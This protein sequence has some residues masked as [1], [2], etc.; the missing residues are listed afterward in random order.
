MHRWLHTVLALLLLA[1]PFLTQVLAARGRGSLLPW[2]ITGWLLWRAG[3]DRGSVR[4]LWLGLGLALLGGSLW[5]GPQVAHWVPAVAFLLVAW[6]F[7]RT[8]V[9]PPPLI[10]RIVRLQFRDIPPRLLAYTRRLTWIWAFF[11]LITAGISTGLTM[12][13]SEHGWLW[14]HGIGAYLAMAGLLGGEYL[15]RRWRFP[16]LDR[17]PPPHETLREIVKHGKRLWEE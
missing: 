6:G 12:A 5:L 1:Y 4:W 9:H 15:Y 8:L 2:L 11:F 17:A 13:G 7:G 16:E 14:F 10:E 3:R